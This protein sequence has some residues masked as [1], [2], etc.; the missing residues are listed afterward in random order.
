[1]LDVEVVVADTPEAERMVAVINKQP[2]VFFSHYLVEQEL[3]HFFVRRLV[4][5]AVCPSKVH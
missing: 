5:A 4:K 3:P 2:T 1:M